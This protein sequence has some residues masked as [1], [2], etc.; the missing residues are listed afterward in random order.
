M[1]DGTSPFFDIWLISRAFML[2]ASRRD[3]GWAR[4]DLGRQGLQ[5]PSQAN[6]TPVTCP[7]LLAA[8]RSWRARVEHNGHATN[9]LRA[10]SL[11]LDLFHFLSI[12]QAVHSLRP[13]FFSS[14][15]IVLMF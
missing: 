2:Q 7:T 15:T 14:A 4:V 13:I 9:I 11:F 6:R 1:R 5:P 10:S 12:S 3:D 8:K